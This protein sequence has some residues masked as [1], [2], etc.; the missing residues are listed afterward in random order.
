M[1]PRLRPLRPLP[2]NGARLFSH[3]SGRLPP[4]PA[5]R[6]SL[7][8]P[9]HQYARTQTILFCRPFKS[10]PRRASS[11]EQQDCYDLSGANQ[12]KC[13]LAHTREDKWGWV[14]YR[15][16]YSP[17][18]G[19][20]WETFKRVLGDEMK[21]AAE[22]TD[23][24]EIADALDL[25]FVEDAALEGASLDELRRRF[26]EWARRENPHYDID[27]DSNLASRGSRFEFFIQV[28]EGALRSVLDRANNRVDLKTGYVN[29]A[30]AWR[31]SLPPREAID[32]FGEAVDNEDW[33]RV[34]PRII[35]EAEFYSDMGDA[36]HHSWYL[37]HRPPPGVLDNDLW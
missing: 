14:V 34:L 32:E 6:P 33:M 26:R 17:E 11:Q 31:D 18:L 2:L 35:V 36:D 4:R 23:A 24:P 28:D 12:I 16:T 13:W 37:N 3:H 8:A 22:A 29:M 10:S 15:C 27:D 1:P 7:P 9:A 21:R 5:H 19:S 30:Q 20:H 25:V